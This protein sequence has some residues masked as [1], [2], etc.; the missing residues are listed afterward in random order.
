MTILLTFKMSNQLR[1]CLIVSYMI[2]YG[3]PIKIMYP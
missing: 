1:L 2:H 3:S